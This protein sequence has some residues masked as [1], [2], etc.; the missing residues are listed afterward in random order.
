ME[1][2]KRFSPPELA[3]L[4]ERGIREANRNGQG[5]LARQAERESG[6]GRVGHF[7][8]LLWG[9]YLRPIVEDGGKGEFGKEK[10]VAGSV[11]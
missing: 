8:K 9:R 10:A 5:V 4:E 1:E 2:R 3:G 11:R 7:R 6:K